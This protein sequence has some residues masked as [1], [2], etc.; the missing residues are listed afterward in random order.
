MY[1]TVTNSID[2]SQ[3]SPPEWQKYTPYD[4]KKTSFVHRG[5]L[6]AGNTK[7]QLSNNN[8]TF[9][10]HWQSVKLTQSLPQTERKVSLHKDAAMNHT[11]HFKQ[12]FRYFQN[13][14]PI[15]TANK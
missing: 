1:K 3:I 9:K 15:Y 5:K 8:C 12:K 7:E 6:I 14:R 10:I 13:Y 11:V 2:L 4:R